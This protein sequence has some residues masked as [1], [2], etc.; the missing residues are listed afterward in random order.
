M[1]LLAEG[2]FMDWAMTVAFYKAVHV[3]EAVLANDCHFHS[4]SHTER[5]KSLKLPKY[6]AIFTSYGHLYTG[7]RVARYLESQEGKSFTTFA[8]YMDGA[9]V[10][11]VIR[12]R[13][14]AV[15]QNS[16]QFLTNESRGILRR[17]DPKKM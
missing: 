10:V 12:R 5:E 3:V 1:K 17:L 9:T 2:A 14:F 16:L 11:D 15:E 8:T 4:T 13:L 6:K 7:S